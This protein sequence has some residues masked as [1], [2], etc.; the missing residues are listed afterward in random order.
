MVQQG[1]TIKVDYKGILDDGS[2]FD[3]SR[4]EA[5]LEFAVGAGQ[6]I[7]GF[8]EGV[9]GMKLNEEKSI[10]LPPEEAYGMPDPNLVRSF[11]KD[12]FPEDVKVEI[13]QRL[14]LQDQSGQSHPCTVT[15]IAQ[16]SVSLDFNHPLAGK[17]LT[18]EIKV[19]EIQ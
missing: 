6:L 3:Q 10:T 8:D 4:Q 14:Q 18:F 13:G 19:V 2:I 16:D 11:Q 7:R 15:E 9:L 17:T 5:P 12:F 1:D